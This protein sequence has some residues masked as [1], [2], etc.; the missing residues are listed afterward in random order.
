[1]SAISLF[2]RRLRAAL[3]GLAPVW[4]NAQIAYLEWACREM[5]PLHPD[6]PEVLSRLSTLRDRRAAS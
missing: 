1:M 4:I 6:L 3:S 5:D 2:P